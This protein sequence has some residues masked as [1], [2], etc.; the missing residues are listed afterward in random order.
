MPGCVIQFT[1]YAGGYPSSEDAA[2]ARDHLIRA[3]NE[4]NYNS[5]GVSFRYTPILQDAC[6]VLGYGGDGGGTLAQAFFP[7]GNDISNVIVYTNCFLGGWK[8]NMWCVFV[9]EL[10]HVL[11]LRHEFAIEKEGGAT[12]WGPKDEYSVMNYRNEPPRLTQN[13][14]RGAREFYNVRTPASIGGMMVKDWIPDN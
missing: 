1:A 11:G 13:D 2:W 10:G 6:F 8:E 4:W 9:H 7:N 3:A 14:V 5:I 12:Q